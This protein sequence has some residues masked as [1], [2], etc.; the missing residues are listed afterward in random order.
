[1]L[2]VQVVQFTSA[3]VKLP[4]MPVEVIFPVPVTTRAAS[5]KGFSVSA[6]VTIPRKVTV[7]ALRACPNNR[8]R[9]GKRIF[10]I[11]KKKYVENLVAVIGVWRDVNFKKAP[12]GSKS[13]FSWA[14][15]CGL[16]YCSGRVECC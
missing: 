13:A 11:I 16:N 3:N 12:K 4:S 9:L 6:S 5:G 15:T 8:N 7:W 10:R 1:M 14:D 2:S